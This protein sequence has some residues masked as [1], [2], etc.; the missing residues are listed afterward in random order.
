MLDEKSPSAE[1]A[2]LFR[3]FTVR[4]AR[5]S[6]SAGQGF[7]DSKVVAIAEDKA[8]IDP[9]SATQ[10]ALSTPVGPRSIITSQTLALY[11]VIVVSS[12]FFVEATAEATWAVV[13]TKDCVAEA[14]DVAG[15][16]G[17][18]ASC[19]GLAHPASTISTETP[20][21]ARQTLT[22]SF[23]FQFMPRILTSPATAPKR[24]CFAE[25]TLPGATGLRSHWQL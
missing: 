12:C 8:A 2:V 14:D 10:L 17:E 22:F 16:S 3:R 11:R 20:A 18:F 7:C 21:A 6:T 24:A 4:K 13:F 19:E 5:S 23:L 25:S 1:A 15:A 9:L